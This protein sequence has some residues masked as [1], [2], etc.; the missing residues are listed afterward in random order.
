MYLN[1]LFPTPK[2]F[3]ENDAQRFTFGASLAVE[4]PT[5]AGLRSTFL[6]AGV[7]F[8]AGRLS[9]LS[10]PDFTGEAFT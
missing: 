9:T 10:F 7:S 6:E 8:L 2:S 1:N 4:L 5:F 3:S